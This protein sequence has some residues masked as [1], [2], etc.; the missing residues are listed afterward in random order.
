MIAWGLAGVSAGYLSKVKVNRI[1]LA[2]F[3]ALWGYLYG[4]I[5]NI[6]FWTTFI[7]PLTINTFIITQINTVWFDTF[8]AVGN[9]VFMAV[10]GVKTITTLQRF[11]MR[12][13]VEHYAS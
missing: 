4:L 3:G 6:W 1:L 2:A 12:F 5:T 13:S 8:H 7:Y 10:L 11:K 9:A